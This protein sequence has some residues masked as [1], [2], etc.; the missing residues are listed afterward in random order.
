LWILLNYIVE[1]ETQGII[2]EFN[3]CI[4][5]GHHAWRATVSKNLRTGYYWPNLFSEVNAKV[6]SC[7]EYHIFA[8]KQNLP[9]FQ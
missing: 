3:K 1:E 4:C 2:D 8:G 7:K 6:R 9:R 5:G